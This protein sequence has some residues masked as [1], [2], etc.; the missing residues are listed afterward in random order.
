MCITRIKTNTSINSF[1]NVNL[2]FLQG[3]SHEI[4]QNVIYFVKFSFR[5]LFYLPTALY[6][7]NKCHKCLNL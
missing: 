3:I 7:R 2:P 6:I 1:K 5:M 4:M